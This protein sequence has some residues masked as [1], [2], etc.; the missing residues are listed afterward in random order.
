VLRG[1]QHN[2][3]HVL[4]DETNLLIEHDI[5]DEEFKNGLVRKDL[6][7]T[8]NFMVD[9]GK[10][11]KGETSHGSGNMKGGQGVNQSGGSIAES[12]LGQN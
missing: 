12:D 8:Q 6:S 9:N 3:V 10:S 7:L 4:F 1:K 5:Q 11:P 2:N